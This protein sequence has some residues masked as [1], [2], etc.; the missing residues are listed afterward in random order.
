MTVPVSE[1]GYASTATEWWTQL[2]EEETPELQWPHNIE[3]YDRMRRQDGQV[4]SVLRAMTLPIR[5]TKWRIDPNGARPEVARQVADD[6]GLPLVGE[7]NMPVLRTRDRFSWAEHLRLS[8]LML[9]FGHSVFEQ[10]Y[11]IDESGLARL[12]KL[13]WRPPKTISRVDVAPDGGLVAIYQHGHPSGGNK[14]AK[15]GV[16]RL[17][18]Y[19]NEREGGNWLGQSLLRPAY[20]YWLLKDRLLRVQAQTVD[21]NGMG[22][23]VYE[24]S[25]L[26]DIV[27]GEDRTKRE[28]DELDSGLIL[29][30]GFRSGD[31]S[32]A[33]IPNSAK[34]ALKGVEGT[35]PDADKPIRYYDEQIARGVLAHFLNL[36]TE[37]GSWALG[38]TFAD[39][40]TLSLQTVAMQIAD[41]T[42]QHVIEDL[43]DVNWGPNE[44]A[45]RL[46]FEEIGS[47]HPATAEAIKA[48]IDSGAITADQKLDDFLR[49]TYGLPAADPTTAR[50]PRTP[51]AQPAPQ[52]QPPNP[53]R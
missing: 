51:V 11:R 3:V 20:K 29:A 1:R 15:M 47:R 23:P 26:P 9:P 35:L 30:K 22:V 32:G 8:L 5:R 48:L 4:I 6:M 17:A 12:R 40:F 18:V 45:P 53:R 16:E 14:E 21:R 39:F 34:L 44:P 46:V 50:E 33:S 7:E 2:D 41:T 27:T 13:A 52:P 10:V 28:K 36:G 42:T 49:T 24:G 31:N 43:V 37:T 25:K 38:S 19:V